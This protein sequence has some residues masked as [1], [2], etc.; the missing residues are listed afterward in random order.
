M[1][2]LQKAAEPLRGSAGMRR[3][4][5]GGGPTGREVG[6][7]A[8]PNTVGGGTGSGTFVDDPASV[9]GRNGGGANHRAGRDAGFLGR[10]GI[11][12]R[13]DRRYV[14]HEVRNSSRTVGALGSAVH[15]STGSPAETVPSSMTRR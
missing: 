5:R 2:V 1:S 4:G 12:R 9:A 14:L 3:V 15:R 10:A 13:G 11:G 8:N 6:G 7:L